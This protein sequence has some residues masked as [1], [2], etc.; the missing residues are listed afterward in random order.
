VAHG[1]HREGPGPDQARGELRHAERDGARDD[2]C[3]RA[4]PGGHDLVVPHV[5]D[6]MPPPARWF[7]RDG[8]EHTRRV[9]KARLRYE[10]TRQVT[11]SRPRRDA[12]V[13]KTRG[14]S[15]GQEFAHHRREGAEG[16]AAVADRVLL[17][18]AHLGGGAGVA[19]GHEDRVVPEP[20]GA[21]RRTDEPP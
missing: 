20:A 14:G 18:G 11:K 1:H 5:T 2:T 10:R 16:P 17:G 8:Y 4:R 12:A 21:A 15:R 6:A 7:L 13:M 9:T 19:V 3:Q